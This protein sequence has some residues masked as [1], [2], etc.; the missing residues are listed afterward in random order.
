[1][2]KGA[3]LTHM[4]VMADL[5]AYH[6]LDRSKPTKDDTM[7]S[8][9]PLAHM[10][11]RV[12]ETIVYTLGGRVGFYG[13]DIKLLVED[14]QELKPTI[15]PT[16]PRLLNRVYDKV[17]N[18]VNKS[19]IKRFLFSWGMS[20]KISEVK[21]GVIRNDSFWDTYVF[22]KVQASMGGRLRVILTGSAPLSEEVMNF[23][24]ATMGCYVVEGYGQTECVA[25]ATLTIEGD[26]EP[27]QVGP[28]IA[29][30]KIKMVDVKEMNYFAKDG[31]GEVCIFGPH[32]MKGYYKL[33]EQTKEVLDDD[34]WLHTGD[35]GR[36]TKDGTLKLIDRKKHIFKLSQGEYIA[37]EKIED[38]YN[39]T[40]YVAQSFIYGE[41]LRS[42]IVAIVVPDADTLIPVA[43]DQLGITGTLSE[44]CK[45]EEVKSFIF[46]DMRAA[47]QKAGLHSF[48]QAKAIHLH[49]ELFSVENGL[50][51][52]TF[53]TKRN[54]LKEFF[55]HQISRMYESIS[56][57][58]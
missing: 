28:P 41:S 38:V 58:N 53:K 8:Y 3:M 25:G 36:W 24:R 49:P 35:I 6:N 16:V 12:M 54:S 56:K 39:R 45:N 21:N 1:M 9:L 17:M 4:N 50:L 22:K 31:C 48:E 14:L 32:V 20:W 46:K 26:C 37:P 7:I 18:E 57:E 11:E 51:T 10:F 43:R 52:P 29:C 33:P 34:G 42:T 27:C 44:L 47:A 2:P 19:F 5:N 15:M 55:K 30:S 40:H 13:G 23:C